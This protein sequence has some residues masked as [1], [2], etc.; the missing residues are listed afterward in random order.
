[1]STNRRG[2]PDDGNRSLI[3]RL[4]KNAQEWDQIEEEEG[5]DAIDKIHEKRTKGRLRKS[6]FLDD[7]AVESENDDQST[8]SLPERNKG[9]WWD[10]SENDDNGDESFNGPLHISPTGRVSVPSSSSNAVKRMAR[11]INANVDLNSEEVRRS[12]RDRRPVA[13]NEHT[14]EHMEIVMERNR[15]AFHDTSAMLNVQSPPRNKYNN[16][17]AKD[18]ALSRFNYLRNQIEV[19][20]FVLSMRELPIIPKD[21]WKNMAEM[22]GIT[23][24]GP[25]EDIVAYSGLE[26][27]SAYLHESTINLSEHNLI[28]PG[29]K[30]VLP[31]TKTD[32]HLTNARLESELL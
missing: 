23:W 2:P 20:L 1:M 16:E 28:R 14:K 10:D 7:A 31:L 19:A 15:V 11:S 30:I 6:N 26:S 18:E 5:S 12:G 21:L 3:A 32:V 24:D 22:L 27:E 29:R 25:E 8:G 17:E 9:N 13:S 4:E